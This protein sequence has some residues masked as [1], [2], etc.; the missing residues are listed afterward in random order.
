[1]RK[2]RCMDEG[3]IGLITG[4]WFY[5]G[6]PYMFSVLLELSPEATIKSRPSG[7]YNL[8]EGRKSKLLISM[9]PYN[10]IMLHSYSCLS[11]KT[12]VTVNCSDDYD[13]CHISILHWHWDACFHNMYQSS[14]CFASSAAHAPQYQ[15]FQDKKSERF[16]PSFDLSFDLSS[17]FCFTQY[18]GVRAHQYEWA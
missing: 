11:Q 15:I 9:S 16:D 3:T 13:E 8:S 2:L 18:Y 7:G 4:P 12:P 10:S 1:M 14:I 6:V 5:K 17:F